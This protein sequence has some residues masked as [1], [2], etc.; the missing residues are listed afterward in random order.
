VSWAGP[1]LVA[2]DGKWM[3]KLATAE[4]SP[5]MAS[6]AR[7][8]KGFVSEDQGLPIARAGNIALTK[9]L[10]SAEP[11]EGRLIGPSGGR[12]FSRI[13]AHSTAGFGIKAIARPPGFPMNTVRWALGLGRVF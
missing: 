10:R 2:A 7:P 3:H 9:I 13:G 12:L 5:G 11:D 6:A 8:R 4:A 1:A